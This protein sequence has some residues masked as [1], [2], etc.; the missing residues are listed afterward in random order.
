MSKYS[1]TISDYSS[2]K[3]PVL[4]NGMISDCIEKAKEIGYDAVEM[5][6]SHPS[7]IDID[8][9][10]KSL[11]RTK[12]QV[13]G[14]ATGLTYAMHK[15][16]FIDDSKEIRKAAVARVNEYVDVAEKIG[17]A[18]IIGCVRGNIPEN[19]DKTTYLDRLKD[20][21]LN[22][23]EYAGAKGV[24]V[25]LEAINRYENNFLN[26]G[27]ET[28]G[29]INSVGMPNLKLLLDTFHMNIEEKDLCKCITESKDYLGYMHFA[30]SNRGYVGDGHINYGLIFKELSEIGYNGAISAECLPLP[31]RE[32]AAVAWL[33]NVNTF[34]MH[35][36]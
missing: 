15:L 26:T 2:M 5:H 33:K 24:M 9:A 13:T 20:A 4:L 17:G 21:L 36:D 23:T 34:I 10:E 27:R 22:I 8:E 29:F 19:A 25:V 7:L 6:Y 30:D 11:A 3:A 35:S 31:D 32:S 16:S 1:I 14:I 18:V 28:I 12:L